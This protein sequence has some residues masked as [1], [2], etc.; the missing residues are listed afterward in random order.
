MIP[1]IRFRSPLLCS[2][3]LFSHVAM[4]LCSSS[5]VFAI[6]RLH[7]VRAETLLVRTCFGLLSA[8]LIDIWRFLPPSIL[9][10]DCPL[11]LGRIA[12]LAPI[13]HSLD[14]FCISHCPCY[15][16][17][18]LH[19]L[20]PRPLSFGGLRAISCI[21]RHVLRCSACPRFLASQADLNISGTGSKG[22]LSR[23]LRLRKHWLYNLPL[24]VFSTIL[25]L[26][27]WP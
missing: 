27:A 4:S 24:E 19:R 22:F 21:S 23:A 8:S 14:D 12:T 6:V 7:L 26:E 18:R 9:A 10:C 1:L 5:N 2:V 11:V 20:I 16:G 13:Y 15:R 25:Y 17:L 3:P